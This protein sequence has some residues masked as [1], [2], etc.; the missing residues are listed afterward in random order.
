[1]SKFKVTFLVTTC[2]TT[3]ISSIAFAQS[4]TETTLE[5]IIIEG[6]KSDRITATTAGD[7][8]GYRALTS[9]SA[10]LTD[11]PL[12]QVPKSVQVVPRSVLDDQGV[13]SI[14]DALK[15][16]SGAVGQPALQTPAYNASYIR[17]FLAD[18]YIDGMSTYLNTGDPNSMVDVERIEVLKGASSILYGG[19]TGAAPGGIINIVSKQPT[20]E[21]FTEIGGT[22]GSNG[23]YAPFFDINQP[24][25]HEGTIL[26]RM[27]GTYVKSGSNVNVIDTD[28]YS[29]NPT[30][31]F[32]RDEDTKLTLQ[33]RLSKW[34]Q[35]E[36]QG[37]PTYGTVAGP[38][39]IDRDLFIGN[40]N[41]PDSSSEAKSITATLDHRFDETWS[42][43]TKVRLG[44]NAYTQ[45]SQIFISATPDLG[46]STWSLANYEGHDSYDEFSVSSHILGEF[47]TGSFENKLLLGADYSS[48]K[49]DLTSSIDYYIGSVDLT[50]PGSWPEFT[51]P[52]SAPTV[53]NNQYL[54]YGAFA[55][56]QSTYA[57]RLHVLASLRLAR[58]EIDQNSTATGEDYTGKTKLLPQL[59]AVYDLTD[60][61]SIF[62]DYG[63]GMK[64]NPFYAFSE[65][66]QPEFSRQYQAGLKFEFDNGFSGSA[67]VFQIERKNVP[68]LDTSTLSTFLPIGNDRSRGVDA[69]L[70][71]QPDDHWKIIANYAYVDAELTKDI[72]DAAAGNHLIMI[73]SHSGGVWASYSFG[74]NGPLKNWTIGAGL[75]A[76]SGSYANPS[77]SYKT[78]SYV[79]TDAAIGYKK[80]GFSANL[81]VKNLTDEKY[82]LPYQYLTY[83]VAPAAGR[84]A[85]LTISQ[86][87]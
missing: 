86:R 85:F 10:T 81:V 62:A 45:R 53:Q 26:F 56:L 57:D 3:Q 8:D 36:Y 38:F 4:Q 30:V 42:S 78:E 19:G 25:N 65:K 13:T 68:V 16:V 14:N 27:T 17:G 50:N 76:A 24:L 35:Q 51:T 40:P 63:Q 49:E 75:H 72:P 71:W 2:L 15:N 87:F 34:Q 33:V 44:T 79:T 47:D 6:V 39:R 66:A 21:R 54:T 28:R 32:A 31:T 29:I 82:Y 11:V 59:G 5:P 48:L 20:D 61:V 37:L 43:S 41:V 18:Q 64:G 67:A 84:S 52:V 46:S 9:S 22:I 83:G 69:E 1:M 74:E 58:V 70:T 12:K 7:V 80:N 60:Q 73:P 77:N 55:Q 23:Y